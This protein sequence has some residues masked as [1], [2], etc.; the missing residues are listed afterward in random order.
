[1][2]CSF[3]AQQVQQVIEHLTIE[4]VRIEQSDS[5]MLKAYIE[6]TVSGLDLLAHAHQFATMV[7][8]HD[9]WLNR[10]ETLVGTPMLNISVEYVLKEFEDSMR[11]KHQI[12][13]ASEGVQKSKS[14]EFSE[15][16]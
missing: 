2:Y 13:L 9:W 12:L 15:F 3:R 16:C 1:M 5:L 11:Q 10:Q 4:G 7:D 14:D 6:E 8:Y